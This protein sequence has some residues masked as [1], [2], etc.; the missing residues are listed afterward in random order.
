MAQDQVL[1]T[2]RVSQAI[3]RLISDDNTGQPQ[4]EQRDVPTTG[5]YGLPDELSKLFGGEDYFNQYMEFS[6]DEKV[7]N[8][9]EAFANKFNNKLSKDDQKQLISEIKSIEGTNSKRLAKVLEIGDEYYSTSAY[10]AIKEAGSPEA[11]VEGLVAEINNL[12]QKNAEADKKNQILLGN[13]GET[14]LEA[15]QRE[16]ISVLTEELNK[17]QNP[18]NQAIYAINKQKDLSA[19]DINFVKT[20]KENNPLDNLWDEKVIVEL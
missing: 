4:S 8:K 9:M 17:M 19:E 7:E 16:K 18:Y 14:P 13:K 5:F 15:E 6:Q 3:N 10:G 11:L 2:N 1:D 20:M 12:K